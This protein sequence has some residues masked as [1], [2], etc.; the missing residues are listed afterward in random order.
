MIKCFL[1]PEKNFRVD[2]IRA[3]VFEKKAKAA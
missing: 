3:L 2:Q 1:N